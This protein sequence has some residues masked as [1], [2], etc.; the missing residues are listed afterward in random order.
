[1][2]LNR[3]GN[4]IILIDQNKQVLFVVIFLPPLF[5]DTEIAW[6]YRGLKKHQTR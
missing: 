2:C 1:M 5:K 3:L 4:Q 6:I